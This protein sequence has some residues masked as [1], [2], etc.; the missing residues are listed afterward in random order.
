MS[1]LIK[2]VS[3]F[4]I[5]EGYAKTL[6]GSFGNPGKFVDIAVRDGAE[7]VLDVIRPIMRKIGLKT[8]IVF[9]KGSESPSRLSHSTYGQYIVDRD[10]IVLNSDFFVGDYG[11]SR[12]IA[13]TL[14]TTILHE[15]VHAYQF[16]VL[17]VLK[18]E[19]LPGFRPESQTSVFFLGGFRFGGLERSAHAFDVAIDWFLSERS[20]VDFEGRLTECRKVAERVGDQADFSYIFSKVEEIY[21][22]LL[23]GSVSYKDNSYLTKALNDVY[24]N[25]ERSIMR[26]L[27]ITQTDVSEV[28]SSG[29][30]L[31]VALSFYFRKIS[32]D[33]KRLYDKVD[34][35]IGKLLDNDIHDMGVLYNFNA[36]LRS[37]DS[38]L[39]TYIGSSDKSIRIAKKYL[40]QLDKFNL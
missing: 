13:V 9:D 2:N 22:G 11:M 17:P 23:K 29:Y 40:R 21:V 35:Y 19:N 14:V 3:G 16:K 33:M 38:N 27:G 20:I 12:T 32:A 30:F 28:M 25:D 4:L 34:Y 24:T 6:L 10:L 37:F 18:K 31:S 26:M 5:T 1:Y 15:I 39:D 36:K 8:R 7:A